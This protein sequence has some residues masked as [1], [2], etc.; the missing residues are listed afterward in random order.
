[1]WNLME[2]HSAQYKPGHVIANMET[3]TIN[4]G[5]KRAG[6]CAYSQPKR[7][8]NEGIVQDI[9]SV[10]ELYKQD[11]TTTFGIRRTEK[12]S[13]CSIAKENDKPKVKVLSETA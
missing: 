3:V 4:K 5:R 12:P 10:L 6:H 13:S 1:M 9:D 7:L 11:T 2:Y 8:D